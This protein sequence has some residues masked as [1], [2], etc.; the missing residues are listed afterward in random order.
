M[1]RFLKKHKVLQFHNL[2]GLEVK[3]L[4]HPSESVKGL[5]GVRYF[6]YKYKYKDILVDNQTIIISKK[7]GIPFLISGN[8]EAPNL[9][10]SPK[11]SEMYRFDVFKKSVDSLKFYSPIKKAIIVK[12]NYSYLTYKAL[13]S[14]TDKKGYHLGD[15][16]LD[17]N[18]F[19]IIDFHSNKLIL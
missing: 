7:D 12:N 19:D 1:V 2:I 5:S 17:S 9:N 6:H 4:E 16:Y 8:F 15:I 13:I 10:L 18:T 3:V 14:Y 11:Y